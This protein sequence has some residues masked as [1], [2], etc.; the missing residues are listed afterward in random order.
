MMSC[1]YEKLPA[2]DYAISVY[3][4]E[5]DNGQLD[6]NA[7]GSPTEGYGATSNNIPALSA[8]TFADNKVHLGGGTLLTADI[9][10]KN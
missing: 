10:L 2:G 1:N 8:P 5:N 6:T 3:Q 9:N 7:L 4:D